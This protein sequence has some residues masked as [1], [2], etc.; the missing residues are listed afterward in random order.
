MSAEHKRP[1]FAFVM[2]TIL[3]AVML[4][5]AIR[6]DAL[7]GLL[8]SLA[9][10]PVASA[11]VRAVL[12][13]RAD[14]ATVRVPSGHGPATLTSTPEST[15]AAGS[16]DTDTTRPSR[17]TTGSTAVAI[18]TATGKAKPVVPVAT[19]QD[20]TVAVTPTP[21]TAT[22]VTDPVETVT[23]PVET[24]TTAPG[25][26]DAAQKA[27]QDKAARDAQKAADKAA[28]DAQKA[29]DKAARDAQQAA[30]DAVLEARQAVKDGEKAARE[31]EKAAA[32]AAKDA[33]KAAK[34]HGNGHG[35][36]DPAVTTPVPD[37]TVTPE[38]PVEA[39]PGSSTKKR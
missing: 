30:D 31:A 12:D 19:T 17:P 4:G 37:G 8:G 11:P 2:V 24:L 38:A 13:P 15:L 22:T 21:V 32:K 1:L 20:P 25:A 27:G 28:R 26:D 6:S 39:G 29:A 35:H 7:V 14:P 18:G 16:T 9:D 33:E 5:H 10:R 36:Q 23:D 34:G 3:C